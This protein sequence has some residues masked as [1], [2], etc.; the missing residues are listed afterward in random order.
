[1][2]PLTHLAT[3]FSDLFKS[4]A[5]V[6]GQTQ[7]TGKI[8]ERD[9]KQDSKSFLVKSKLTVD[10]W[11]EHLT[12]KKLIGCTPIL[13][14]STVC[15]GCLDIDV[16]QNANTIKDLNK[17]IAEHNLPFVVCPFRSIGRLGFF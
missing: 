16:Y 2:I 10:I 9:G 12:G 11:E 17:Q 5:N 7:L 8:R 15:W 6:Y 14:D 4:N 1:M 13:E 3:Q